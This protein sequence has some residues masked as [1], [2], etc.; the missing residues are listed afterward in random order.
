MPAVSKNLTRARS[1]ENE[2]G[3]GGV[4][5][6]TSDPEHL[7]TNI[8]SILT[9]PLPAADRRRLAELFGHWSG[10]GSTAASVAAAALGRLTVGDEAGQLPPVTSIVTPVTKSASLEARKQI[11]LA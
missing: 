4:L 7:R 8:A 10:S 6:G 5:F 2:P 11:T 3:G 9:P 1:S